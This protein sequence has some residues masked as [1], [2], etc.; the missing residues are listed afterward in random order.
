MFESLQKYMTP[1][2]RAD[3]N[4]TAVPEKKKILKRNFD[5]SR[6]NRLTQDWAFSPISINQSLRGNLRRLRERS[7][8]SYRNDSYVKKY[9]GLV[10]KNVIGNGIT[11]QVQTLNDRK[12]EATATEIETAFKKWSKKQFCSLSGKLSW[13]AA[14]RLFIQHLVRDG[15][16]LVRKIYDKNNPFGFSL[17]FYDVTW[18]NEVFFGTAPNGNMIFMGIEVDANDKPI[19]YHLTPPAGDVTIRD[20]KPIRVP[21]EEIIHA[22]LIL[23]DET[24]A[25]GVPWLHAS[26][27]KLNMLDGYEEAELVG[28]RIGASNMGFFTQPIDEDAPEGEEDFD[29]IDELEPGQL[30][31]LPPGFDFREFNPK[32]PDNTAEGFKSTILGAAASGGDVA[33][34]SLTGDMSQVNYSSA[35]VAMLDERDFWQ[36]IQQFFIE[37]FCQ[38]VFEDWLKSA[39]LT[40]VVNLTLK[41]Y[42][43]LKE[44]KWF[45][46]GW[47]WV[48][49]EKEV[50]ADVTAINN[51][52]ETV[53]GVLA[54]QGQDLEEFLKIRQKEQQMFEQYG[55]T[56]PFGQQNLNRGYDILESELLRKK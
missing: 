55:I 4:Q 1:S 9:V 34:H 33:K 3:F 24:Q 6:V 16:V 22:F 37:E 44:V 15:E 35:R 49:P 47:T 53:T 5:A 13:L 21:A 50:N 7:R 45:A 28:R 30:K 14:Q 17:K 51:G 43:L 39:M 31:L 19:A 32:N 36:E 41:Q 12:L 38:P 25:R 26:L 10:R 56:Y 48:D 8:D 2:E 27:M 40:N 46:R 54:R 20:R 23:E 29:L 18:L 11:F 42:E 52:L